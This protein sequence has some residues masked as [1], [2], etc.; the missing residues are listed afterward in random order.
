MSMGYNGLDPGHGG[1]RVDLRESEIEITPL[2]VR[3]RVRAVVMTIASPYNVSL[4]QRVDLSMSLDRLRQ[5]QS[6]IAAVL[7]TVSATQPPKER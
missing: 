7:S 5:L 1:C 4:M 6:Q 3:G 2:V